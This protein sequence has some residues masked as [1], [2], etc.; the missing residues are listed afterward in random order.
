MDWKSRRI[1]AILEQ[2]LTEDKATG[3]V[4]TAVAI[5]SS[6]RAAAT[7]IAKEE[8]VL[9]G[10]GSVPRFLD[11]FAR[12]DGKSSGR[13]E[14]I[15]HPEIF[16]GVRLRK[17]QAVAVIRHNARVILGC[18]RVIL[19]LMQR[20]SGIATL[21]RRYVDAVDDTGAK[22]LDTRKT[23]PGLRILDKY[24]VRCGGGEN[25][26]LDL[27][28]GILIKNNHITLGGGI[29]KVLSRARE[30]RKVGQ[31]IDI[32]VRNQHELELALEH[33]AESLLFDNMTPA[34]VKKSVDLVRERG[35][36]VPIEVSGG[37]NLEN[38]RKYALAGPDY[39]SVGALTHSAIAVDLSMRITAEIY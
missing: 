3:D 10:L 2:A 14:V 12:L 19:N 15:S 21:T 29:E 20:L 32:E 27:S 9:A 26:R 28:D 11:I 25:H 17:G 35:F 31:T 36:T 16:D 33:G 13:Y 6:L 24:A 8:C 1:E 39:I 34:E 22:I 4:T 23:I 18:E 38:V 7:I 37:V 5:D 30:R